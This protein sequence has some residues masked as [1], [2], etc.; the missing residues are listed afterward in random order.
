M[1]LITFEKQLKQVP[2]YKAVK[3]TDKLGVEHVKPDFLINWIFFSKVIE[4]RF[5]TLENSI[6]ELKQN[7][8]NI[9]LKPVLMS[10]G[11]NNTNL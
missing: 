6:F 3:Y 1:F 7:V 10:V 11:R 9:K 5:E 8:D 4:I 2:L